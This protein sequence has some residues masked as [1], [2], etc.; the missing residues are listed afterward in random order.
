MKQ[1]KA[2]GEWPG[3]REYSLGRTVVWLEALI[4]LLVALSVSFSQWELPQ[5]DLFHRFFA[6]VLVLI[7]LLGLALWRINRLTLDFRLLAVLMMI[8]TGIVLI[9]I[10]AILYQAGGSDSLFFML[11]I[12]SGAILTIAGIGFLVTKVQQSHRV[13]GYYGLWIFGILLVL[14]M[15]LHELGISYS[16][17][18]LLIG[19]LGLAISVIGAI[20]FAI[21][22]RLVLNVESWITA[23][24]A[25]YIAGKYDE[26]IEYYDQALEME[27]KNDH[28]WGSRGAALLRLGLWAKALDAFNRALETNPDLALAHSGKG[29]ALTHLKRYSEA[30]ASHDRAIELESSPVGWNNRGNTVM[31]M[32]GDTAE[33]IGNY[34]RALGIDPEYDI[35]WF[36]KGKAELQ[37]ENLED[38]IKSFS[39][40]VDLKPKFAEAWFNKGKALS[41]SG[42]NLAE[43]LYCF[44]TAIEL[45]PAMSEAWME[46]KILLMSMKERKIR[47]IPIVNVPRGGHPP[48]IMGRER[49]LLDKSGRSRPETGLGAG[50][51]ER[52]SALMLANQGNYPQAIQELDKRLASNPKDV[53]THMTRGVLLSRV[54]RFDEALENFNAAIQLKPEWVGPLFSKGM[55]LASKGEYD[56]ALE[57]LDKVTELRPN[58]ADAWSVKGIING[59]LR[60]YEQAIDCFDRVIEL[61]PDN[62]DAWRSKSTALN[63]LGRYEEAILCYEGLAGISPAMEETHRVMLEEEKAKLEDARTLFKHGVELAKTSEFERAVEMLDA[64]IQKRPNFVDALY[65][66]GVTY[67]VME[68]LATAMERF[69]RVLELRQDHAEALYG[70]GSIL[71]K[72]ESYNK[73]IDIFDKVLELRPKHVDAWCDRGI[74]LT[75]LGQEQDAMECYDRALKLAGDHPQA[76][77]QRERCVQ[78][79]RQAGVET[80][81]AGGEREV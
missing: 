55:I 35:A 36:N 22:Q 14:F 10:T 20:S 4:A 21:E 15:P 54:E 39:R 8:L 76:I 44:D 2:R 43:A 25:K 16:N 3:S 79:M 52:E 19:Y 29:L 28:V 26:A 12:A 6:G 33:A 62:E 57:T 53:V 77:A 48:G 42:K 11:L 72:I 81:D 18:D 41:M 58:Y 56:Q 49:P 13:T 80:S 45:K 27:P 69:E 74:A 47:P 17:R 38:A 75:K 1:G 63:K 64:A 37:V 40:A 73:A 60:K 30:I 50:A 78:A 65:I 46:R 31:R 23:G 67:A 34:Q 66:S 70:K 5:A 9:S 59:T 71:L 24:D 61:K 68:D 51:K 32:G 7:I